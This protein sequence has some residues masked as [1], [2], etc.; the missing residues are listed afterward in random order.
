L[1]L[2]PL[3]PAVERFASGA[4]FLRAVFRGIEPMFGSI[5]YRRA[6]VAGLEPAHEEFAT[7]VDRPFLLSILGQWSGAI[8]REPLVWYGK[9]GDGDDRHLAMSPAHIL[10]M[11]SLYRATL[12]ERLSGD[13]RDLFY[14]YSGYWLF[15]LYR[16]TPT[17]GRSSLR[18][19]V[20]EAWRDGLYNP[21]WSR[22]LGRKR[23]I[24]LLLTGR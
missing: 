20:F 21:R 23:L 2:R 22:G 24:G 12:P 17:A 19:F 1:Q 7:L 15:T 8:I 9:H 5:V 11:F 14:S 4:D 3:Q 6:A 10:R 16:L 13:D 18:R